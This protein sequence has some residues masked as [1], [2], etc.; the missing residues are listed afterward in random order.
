VLHVR[1]RHD[2]PQKSAAM[3]A[4]ESGAQP[5]GFD[6]KK[7]LTSGKGMDSLLIAI[8][9][10]GLG[11]TCAYIRAEYLFGRMRRA[12]EREKTMIQRELHVSAPRLEQKPL[13]LSALPNHQHFSAKDQTVRFQRLLT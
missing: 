2:I 13:P 3:R 6:R 1:I 8:I 7:C 5:I 4:S 12:Y 9:I 10:A 11:L